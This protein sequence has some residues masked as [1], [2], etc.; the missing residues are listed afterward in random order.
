MDTVKHCCTVLNI[1][2]R[3][4]PAH[5]LFHES[6]LV[7][8]NC[9]MRRGRKPSLMDWNLV[10]ATSGDPGLPATFSAGFTY[11]SVL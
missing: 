10:S 1:R 3:Y 5:D 11:T 6:S 9:T 8:G 2:F 4:L 7:A